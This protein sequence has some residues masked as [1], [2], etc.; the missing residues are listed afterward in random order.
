MASS[1]LDIWSN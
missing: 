1:Q